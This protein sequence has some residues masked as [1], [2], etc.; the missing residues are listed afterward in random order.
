M[1]RCFKR[2]SLYQSSLVNAPFRSPTLDMVSIAVAVIALWIASQI[3]VPL[4]PVPITLQTLA[5]VLTGFLLGSVLGF[6]AAVTWLILGAL[7]LPFFA[8]GAGGI[9][10]LTG[11]TSGYLWSFPFAAAVAGLGAQRDRRTTLWLFLLAISAHLITLG[12]GA[13][14]L[15][16]RIGAEAALLKGVLPFLPGAALK[17]A[18]AAF[19]V[20]CSR[21]LRGL[22]RVPDREAE[23]G[24][25]RD[26]ASSR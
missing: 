23:R 9:E 17:S 25:Y 2:G 4:T 12:A 22:R 18:V 20:S 14:W 6:L 3:A 26:G 16:T 11:P 13:L 15:G 10:H 7:G 8:E 24:R 5:V 19:L 21:R 1:L